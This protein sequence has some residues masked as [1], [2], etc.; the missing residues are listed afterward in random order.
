[1]KSNIA[2]VNY[3]GSKETVNKLQKQ[4]K[5]QNIVIMGLRELE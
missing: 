4:L 2:Q 1:M 5:T 3:N